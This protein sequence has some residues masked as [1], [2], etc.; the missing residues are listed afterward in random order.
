MHIEKM[1]NPESKSI[2]GILVGS[3]LSFSDTLLK[4]SN[5]EM[6]R[7]QFA[8]LD[9]VSDLLNLINAADLEQRASVRNVFVDEAMLSVFCDRL[10][11]LRA[12]FPN[13]QFALAYRQQENA[14]WL[15]EKS[16][17]RADLRAVSL[18][19]MH[20]EVDR[21]LSVVRLLI[22]G[23]Q[24]VPSDL[25]VARVQEA[26]AATG[27][28]GPQSSLEAPA[29]AQPQTGTEESPRV[30]LTEREMQV[31]RSAAEGKPNKIIAEELR[32][33]QHT[34]KL[35]MHHLMAKL[36]VHNRTEAAIWFFDH[37]NEVAQS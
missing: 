22:C 1:L 31:L 21:W 11:D 6:D 7:V 28:T 5:S 13:S 34:I 8:R 36:G 4:I 26:N 24:Y 3:P 20:L 29:T 2:N 16:V 12:G 10:E 37:Q 32:L 33:S 14:H 27:A 19:P 35:H 25:M 23:E 9:D 30:K 15:M 17:E 18:L